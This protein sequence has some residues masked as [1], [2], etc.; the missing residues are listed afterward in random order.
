MVRRCVAASAIVALAAG[1]ALE[2]VAWRASQKMLVHEVRG[3]DAVLVGSLPLAAPLEATLDSNEYLIANLHR[4]HLTRGAM[5]RIET[6]GL[7]AATP[8]VRLLRGEINVEVVS[9]NSFVVTTPD[10]RLSV[11]GT[12]FGVRIAPGGT[13]VEVTHGLVR[14]ESRAGGAALVRGGESATLLEV[15]GVR[16]D[17]EG[18]SDISVA[19]QGLP[20]VV[21]VDSLYRAR[22]YDDEPR[23]AYGAWLREESAWFESR[24]PDVARVARLLRDEFGR[25]TDVVDLLVRSG[26]IWRFRS[27]R[28]CV[29][30]SPAFVAR[31]SQSYH[32]KVSALEQALADGR[33][34]SEVDDN[35]RDDNL[36]DDGLRA[37]K[38]LAAWADELRAVDSRPV[39]DSD[40]MVHL[41][42]AA[43]LNRARTGVHI[44]ARAFPDR[45][46][47]LIQNSQYSR[48]FLRCLVPTPLERTTSTYLVVLQRQ[49]RIAAD[50]LSSMEPALWRRTT[51]GCQTLWREAAENVERL[52]PDVNAGVFADGQVRAA[53]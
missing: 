14:L 27:N 13:V 38:K 33:C 31:V 15:G 34:S 46:E 21:G 11:L 19:R 29:C 8:V 4:V 25:E 41:L 12:A 7:D 43:E 35:L 26:E 16:M 5:V 37:R 6:D 53:H 2:A 20:G 3:G 52:L 44:W 47:R 50:V 42:A 22:S 1:A 49:A 32:L 36:R 39:S 45:L 28:E 17:S 40:V 48:K 30:N 24:F 51:V 10:G 18:A 9:G 23:A